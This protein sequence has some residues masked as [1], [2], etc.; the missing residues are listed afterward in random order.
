[1]PW[2]IYCDTSATSPRLPG[3]DHNI[4]TLIPSNSRVPQRLVAN[5]LRAADLKQRSFTHRSTPSR[6]LSQVKICV[7]KD[8]ERRH[9]GNGW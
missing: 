5:V 6:Q 1:M 9:V 2:G 7:G 8:Q 4:M 3:S